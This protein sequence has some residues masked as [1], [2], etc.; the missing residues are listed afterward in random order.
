MKPLNQERF[1]HLRRLTPLEAIKAMLEGEFGIGD[2]PAIAEAIRKD[3]RITLS[4]D[5]I[6]D[7]L[8]EAMLQDDCGAQKCMNEL[9][10]R[11]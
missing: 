1:E 4:D 2:E 11:S 8:S 9:V 6:V 7:F 5:A 10:M 3:K